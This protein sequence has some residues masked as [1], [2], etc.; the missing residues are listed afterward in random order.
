VAAGGAGL[1]VGP[2]RFAE[3]LD[4][5]QLVTL[6]GANAVVID[7]YA[8]WAEPLDANFQAV[9]AADLAARLGSD[10][11][12]EF[13]GQA[14]AQTAPRAT[15]RVLRFDVDA[16][17]TAVLEVQWGL[18]APDGTPR[19]PGRVSRHTATAAGSDPAA[20]VAALNATVTA[21]SAE[22][23]AAVAATP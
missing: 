14:L 17:G 13:P 16:A 9:L 15:G 5:P 3:Y 20:R 10:R 22:L 8:R 11:V 12:L 7:D 23:A 18:L 21:F 1:V 6:S 19:L 2:F 4:R